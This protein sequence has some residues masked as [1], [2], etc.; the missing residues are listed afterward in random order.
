MHR[1]KQKNCHLFIGLF[2]VMTLSLVS[3]PLF[4][5]QTLYFQSF[6]R[7]SGEFTHPI[8]LEQETYP[9][10]YSVQ[11]DDQ[12]NVQ[13]IQYTFTTDSVKTL[14]YYDANFNPVREEKYQDGDLTLITLFDEMG[15]PI[16][17]QFYEK[18]AIR[19]YV[20]KEYNNPNHTISQ[21]EYYTRLL[22]ENGETTGG[23]FLT[24]VWNYNSNG[25][26]DRCYIY[27]RSPQGRRVLAKTMMY[28]YKPDG[29]L[30]FIQVSSPTEGLLRRSYYNDE[31]NLVYTEFFKDDFLSEVQRYTSDGN[32]YAIEYYEVREI[33]PGRYSHVKVGT[34]EVENLM[35]IPEEDY[36]FF[37]NPNL[38]EFQ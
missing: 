15:Y 33:V 19:A 3:F 38:P 17:I 12:G 24:R 36:E 18:S 20:K 8:A 11:Y 5:D 35:D 16:E 27:E 37:F 2:I 31:G 1:G 4:A 21:E 25:T 23:F 9:G 10:Y 34:Y 32:L 14:T 22:L 7:A 26:L 30:D 13:S 6:D 29:Y 28:Y